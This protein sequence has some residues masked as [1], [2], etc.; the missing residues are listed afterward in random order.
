VFLEWFGILLFN[1][2]WATDYGQLLGREKPQGLL[3]L[4]FGG[5]GDVVLLRQPFEAADDLV[6]RA[7]NASLAGLHVADRG[8]RKLKLATDLGLSEPGLTQAF[9]SEGNI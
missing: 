4:G 1:G 8:L 9:E 7:L 2:W 5:R 6:R 3:R